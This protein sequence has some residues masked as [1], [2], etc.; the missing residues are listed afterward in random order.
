LRF[1]SIGHS[2]LQAPFRAL[3][4]GPSSVCEERI[5]SPIDQR[6]VSDNVLGENRLEHRHVT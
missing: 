6:P 3:V 4:V 2:G 1:T 5:A